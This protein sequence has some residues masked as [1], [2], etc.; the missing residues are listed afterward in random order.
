MCV[1]D[2]KHVK[3]GERAEDAVLERKNEREEGPALVCANLSTVLA[4]L[5]ANM[6]R[7]MLPFSWARRFAA[8]GRAAI[9][10]RVEGSEHEL[11]FVRNRLR[12]S[13]AVLNW[14]VSEVRRTFLSEVARL[15]A[16]PEVR[17]GETAEAELDAAP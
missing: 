16:W 4:V 6:L 1:A 5:G 7:A 17:K 13:D 14:F 15:E 10:G 8:E 2:I 11:A 12:I 3:N 9:L